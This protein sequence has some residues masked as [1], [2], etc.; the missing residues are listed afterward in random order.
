M[1]VQTV[2]TDHLFFVGCGLGTGLALGQN[3]AVGSLKPR[4]TLAALICS[5]FFPMAAKSCNGRPGYVMG[6]LK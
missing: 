6:E 5:C 2:D 3:K 1:Y 4:L